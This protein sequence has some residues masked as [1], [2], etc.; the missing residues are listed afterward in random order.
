MDDSYYDAQCRHW[1]ESQSPV[2]KRPTIMHVVAREIKSPAVFLYRDETCYLIFRSGIL[3]P[4]VITFLDK[5][6]SPLRLR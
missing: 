5:L 4:S 1:G 3:A 2:R 6:L